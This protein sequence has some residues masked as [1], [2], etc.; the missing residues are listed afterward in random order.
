MATPEG[1]TKH[2]IRKW[3]ATVNNSWFFMPVQMG[4]GKAGVPDFIACMPTTI[5]QDMVGKTMGAFLGIEAKAPGKA[6]N[7]TKLQEL[8]I[9]EIKDA[10]G[11]AFVVSSEEELDV[12]K[13]TLYG[14]N[15]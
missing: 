12:V 9:Q 15:S 13:A 14:H 1:A 11:F 2:L 8:T 7:T 6:K 4:Y 3:F 5:T 10:G